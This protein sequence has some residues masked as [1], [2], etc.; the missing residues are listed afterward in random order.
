MTEK[1]NSTLAHRLKNIRTVV[2]ERHHHVRAL[3]GLRAD[4]VARHLA[5]RSDGHLESRVLAHLRRYLALGRFGGAYEGAGAHVLVRE[6]RAEC[7][8]AGASGGTDHEGSAID[9]EQV[10]RMMRC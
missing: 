4:L 5:D 6:E 7:G 2:S 1:L 3:V 10:Q 9:T 8:D